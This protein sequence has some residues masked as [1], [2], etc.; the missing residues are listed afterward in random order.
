[1]FTSR[2][3]I[4]PLLNNAAVASAQH[5]C[6]VAMFSNE[7]G[8]IYHATTLGCQCTT[9]SSFCRATPSTSDEICA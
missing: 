2:F 7:Q 8:V 5:G 1:M 3:V 6:G 9:L 4:M